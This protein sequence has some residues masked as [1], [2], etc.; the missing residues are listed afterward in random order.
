MRLGLPTLLSVLAL[1]CLEEQRYVLQNEQLAVTADTPPAF[2]NEDDV[3]FWVVERSFSMAISVPSEQNLAVLVQ[4]AQG[5]NL[6][7]PR[8]P[9]VERED[10]EYT[11]DYVL[12]NLSDMPLL[13]GIRLDGVNEF[14]AYTPG[15]EDFHQWERL[16]ELGPREQLV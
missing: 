9:W 15:L 12:R 16:V 1:G 2:V 13:A 8:L 10:L 7:F 14:F 3:P 11:V 5:M 4:G 6:P